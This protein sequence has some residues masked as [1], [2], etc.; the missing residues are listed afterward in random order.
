MPSSRDPLLADREVTIQVDDKELSES[1]VLSL[2][3]VRMEPDLCKLTSTIKDF[4]ADDVSPYVQ[5]HLKSLGK[6]DDDLYMAGSD[7]PRTIP[8]IFKIAVVRHLEGELEEFRKQRNSQAASKKKIPVLLQ[9]R[10]VP[11]VV[12]APSFVPVTVQP[13]QMSKRQLAPKATRLTSPVH[14]FLQNSSCQCPI[15]CPFA[16][17]KCTCMYLGL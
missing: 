9:M 8:Q 2:A 13:A 17:M 5:R 15:V 3:A 10:S 11:D 12:A 16:S 7:I 6:A 4:V 14:P 1:L